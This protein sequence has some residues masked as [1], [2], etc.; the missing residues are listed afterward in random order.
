MRNYCAVQF[1][2]KRFLFEI[3]DLVNLCI[4]HFIQYYYFFKLYICA[5]CILLAIAC[6]QKGQKLRPDVKLNIKCLHS[7]TVLPN[8]LRIKIY[9]FAVLRMK[10]QKK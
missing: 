7:T 9:F 10:H 2:C 5:C 1:S 6:A 4:F 8:D 3:Q